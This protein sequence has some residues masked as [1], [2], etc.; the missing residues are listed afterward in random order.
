MMF[1]KKHI[2]LLIFLLCSVH[3][4]ICGFA[5]AG[6]DIVVVQSIRIPPYE[7]AIEGVE[8]L[9][10]TRLQRLVM[11]EFKGDEFERKLYGISPRLI[12]AVG[13]NALAKVRQIKKIPVV[14]MMVLNPMAILSG[15]EQNITG[16]S[17]NIS[18]EKQLAELMKLMPGANNIGLIFDPD[19][20]GFFVSRA[21]KAAENL[22]I[23][24]ITHEVKNSKD[25]IAGI[26]NMKSKVD[27]FWMLPDL[28]VITPETLKFLFLFS[29]ENKIPVMTF[30]ENYLKMGAL[31]SM[32]IDA[33][34]MGRQAGEMVNKILSG[35]K[36]TDIRQVGARK[37]NISINKKIAQKMGLIIDGQILYKDEYYYCL[38]TFFP[39]FFAN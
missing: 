18:Q 3:V 20:T 15:S 37:A 38:K 33:L 19:R 22:D 35:K 7:K 25:V 29:L 6:H 2:L 9:C 4:F 23:N 24:L 39:A 13:A 1:R 21:L 30:S 26:M 32:N 5:F 12:I 8:S 31:I 17:M 34:D 28:T 11:S 36:V 27:I 14:Y 10:G 16:V